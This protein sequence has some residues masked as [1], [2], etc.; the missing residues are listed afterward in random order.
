MLRYKLLTNIY[1][2]QLGGYTFAPLSHAIQWM[3][4]FGLSGL[5]IYMCTT[6]GG[7]DVNQYS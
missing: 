4:L 7:N 2:L 6:F 3:L 1:C 5:I